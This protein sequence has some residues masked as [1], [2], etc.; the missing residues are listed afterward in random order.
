MSNVRVTG[1]TDGGH[2]FDKIY[3]YP[4]GPNFLD[5][6]PKTDEFNDMVKDLGFGIQN[7]IQEQFIQSQ[8]FQDAYKLFKNCPNP[9]LWLPRLSSLV[10]SLEYSE[11][12][13]TDFVNMFVGNQQ[14]TKLLQDAFTNLSNLVAEYNQWFNSLPV[15]QRAQYSQAGIN[16]A[17][18]GGSQ[19]SGSSMSPGTAFSSDSVAAANQSFDNALNF[20]TSTVGGLLDFINLVNGTFKIGLDFKLRDRGLDIQEK[21]LKQSGDSKLQD[22]NLQRGQLGLDPISDLSK[23]DN[24]ADIQFFELKGKNYYANEA[25]RFRAQYDSWKEQAT[26]NAFQQNEDGF[27]AYSD[28][29]RDIGN[30]NLGTRIYNELSAFE[31]SKFEKAKAEF[32][33]HRQNSINERADQLIDAELDEKYSKFTESTALSD[34]HKQLI[35]YKRSVL[36]D[37]IFEAN[38]NP[39]LGWLYSSVLMKSDLNLSEF[40]SPADAGL[41]YL[42]AGTDMIGDII[43]DLNPLGWFKAL[44]KG[45]IKPKAKK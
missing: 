22:L 14:T 41:R 25:A 4:S 29:M 40:M 21:S 37:W 17:L 6:T 8:A 18:D 7:Q 1:P 42:N 28:I 35:D 43:G 2:D 5:G 23:F 38:N 30:I 13:L 31:K 3:G 36:S 26:Y 34:F 24:A 10:S 39:T 15:T 12:I 20:V 16:I 45:K 32:E 19:I 33:L 27:G 44:K 11:G 9:E